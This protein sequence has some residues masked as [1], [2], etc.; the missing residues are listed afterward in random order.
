MNA[1]TL[2]IGNTN[3]DIAFFLND[4]EKFIKTAPVCDIDA[5]LEILEQALRETPV[6]KSSKEGKKD[7]FLL[8]CSVNPDIA[9]R[10]ELLVEEEFGEKIK[11]VGRDIPVPIET[12]LDNVM[13]TG[14]DRLVSAAAAFA[15]VE[16]AVVVADFGSAVT[17]DLVD[18]QGVFLGGVIAPGLEIGAKALSEYTSQLPE[19][20]VHKPKDVYGSNTVD[21]IN[22]GLVYSAVGLLKTVVENYANQLGKWPH[23][24]VTGGSAEIIKDLC[25]FVDSWVP[26]LVVKGILL[27]WKKHLSDEEFFKEI[28]KQGK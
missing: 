6:V 25:S 22:T 19:V 9:E 5:V 12:S 10:I 21:A 17:I 2:D 8:G 13:K 26:H 14:M 24:V 7:I 4:A 1:I 20:K 15:V 18:E 3:I 16:D 23:T 11:L 28:E 27:A